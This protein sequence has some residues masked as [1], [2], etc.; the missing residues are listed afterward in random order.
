MPASDYFFGGSG[1]SRVKASR[2]RVVFGWG[3]RKEFDEAAILKGMDHRQGLGIV[4]VIAHVG[5]EDE[6]C[7][8]GR[9]VGGK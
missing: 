6:L 8:S 1:Q 5:I 3:D 9:K 2:T 7:W 4:D